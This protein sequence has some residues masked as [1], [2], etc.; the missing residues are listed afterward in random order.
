[1]AEKKPQVRKISVSNTKQEMLD[2]YNELQQQ[3]Q[4][5]REAELKPEEKIEEKKAMK[6]VETG[7]SLSIDG[8]MKEIG[9]LKL[10]MGKVFTGLADQLQQE[11][12]KYNAVKQ[13][14]AIKEEELKE[15]FEIQKTASSLNA[16]LEAQR[17]KRDE[18]EEEMAERKEELTQEIE[19]MRLEWEKEKK[20]NTLEIKERVSAETKQREREKEEY[21]YALQR[22]RQLVR[23]QFEDEKA[24]YEEEKA[25]LEKEITEKREGMERE[26]AARE[27]SIRQS[28]QELKE[29]RGKVAAFPGELDATVAREVKVAV[30][31]AKLE[32]K[33]REELLSKESEGERNVFATRIAALE[34]KVKEQSE[35]ITKLAQQH[36]KAYS[37]VQE[38]AIRAVEGSSGAKALSSLQQLLVEQGRGPSQEK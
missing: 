17:R 22:E 32:A 2:A 9:N 10:E 27:E 19:T 33:N 34:N 11:V 35:T 37:Q 18:F 16:L 14:I 21:Q 30:E 15:I 23:N 7:D 28:E 38:I 12:S 31:R 25:R 36:E 20:L 26:F 13:A 4:E 1:M 8:V 6:L 24:G 5:K 29:L 3:L